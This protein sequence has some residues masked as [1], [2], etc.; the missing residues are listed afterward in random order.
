[1]IPGKRPAD[2]TPERALLLSQTLRVTEI[3]KLWGIS[4]TRVYQLINKAEAPRVITE[5]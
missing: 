2:A 4:R 1:M 3:A 5:V